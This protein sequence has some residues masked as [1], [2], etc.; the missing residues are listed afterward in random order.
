MMQTTL[1]VIITYK[2]ISCG[3]LPQLKLPAAL[4]KKNNLSV[5]ILFKF[6]T[7]VINVRIAISLIVFR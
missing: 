3:F 2:T 5:I 1:Y 6:T 7:K 4:Q